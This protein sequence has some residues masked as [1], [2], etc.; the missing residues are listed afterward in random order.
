M[1]KSKIDVSNRMM[2]RVTFCTIIK[3]PTKYNTVIK[4]EV[5]MYEHSKYDAQNMKRE[6]HAEVHR[7]HQHKKRCT[8][9]N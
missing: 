1:H 5:R 9:T 6:Y 3:Q 7:K 4:L 8:H 2:R